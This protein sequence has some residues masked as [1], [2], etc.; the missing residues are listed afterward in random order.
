MRTFLEHISIRPSKMVVYTREAKDYSKVSTTVKKSKTDN[1]YVSKSEQLRIER[2]RNANKHNFELSKQAQKNI[3]DKIQW[4]YHFARKKTVTSLNGKVLS[5]FK[6]SFVTLTLPST[7]VHCS[8]HITGDYLNQLFVELKA[9]MGIENYVWR[10]EYQKNGNIHYH[11][12]TDVFLNYYLLRNIWNRIINKG[13]YVDSY[14]A[15]MKAMT[16]MDYVRNYT[17][18]DNSNFTEL[19]E[20]YAKGCREGWVNPSSVDVKNV[21]NSKA[22]AFYISK[23]F[24]KNQQS[25]VG[26]AL[27]VNDANSGNSR[28]WFCSRALSRLKMVADIREALDQDYLEF[29][30]TGQNVKKI[31]TDYCTIFYYN[32]VDLCNRGKV[33]LRK[34]FADYANDVGYIGH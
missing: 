10:L 17:N 6:M 26:I 1:S 28:L 16:L 29:M 13:G 14:T 8:D 27:A 9:K 5:D 32:F 7:Q 18:A 19:Q 11:I 2:V 4:L 34:L 12:A 22:I 33:A 25:R 3:Q 21:S 23:Y 24:G 30:F 20:R 31:V 15:K